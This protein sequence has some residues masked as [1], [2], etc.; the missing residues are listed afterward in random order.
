MHIINL[1]LIINVGHTTN[2]QPRT[3][4]C[5]VDGVPYLFPPLHQTLLYL[6]FCT[7]PLDLK[8]N[9]VAFMFST[10]LFQPKLNK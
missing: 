3:Y 8:E 7:G 6:R 10:V 5:T 2:S 1:P 4:I 9:T